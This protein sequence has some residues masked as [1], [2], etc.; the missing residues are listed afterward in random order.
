MPPQASLSLDFF[1]GK[2]EIR[3]LPQSLPEA[4]ARGDQCFVPGAGGTSAPPPDAGRFKMDGHGSRVVVSCP[5]ILAP[6]S[7]S[8]SCSSC[9]TVSLV[10]VCVER[11][12]MERSP[13]V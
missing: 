13:H 6:I 9:L 8:S 5:V 10:T 4:P 3:L 12:A 11:G 1:I 7:S 2:M